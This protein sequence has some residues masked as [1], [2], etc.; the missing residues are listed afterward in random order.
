MD[1]EYLTKEKT[2]SISDGERKLLQRAEVDKDNNRLYTF[3][4]N[5]NILGR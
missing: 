4:S 5:R 3:T 1:I 2:S